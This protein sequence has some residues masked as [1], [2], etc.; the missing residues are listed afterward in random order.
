MPEENV[1]H[2]RGKRKINP[3]IALEKVECKVTIGDDCGNALVLITYTFD[4]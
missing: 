4:L 1:T 3:D 2:Y